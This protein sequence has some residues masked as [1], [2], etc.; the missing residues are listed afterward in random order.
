MRRILT[1]L[2]FFVLPPSAAKN[3]MVRLLG[4][5]EVHPTAILGHILILNCDDLIMGPRARIGNLTAL[6]GLRSLRLDADSSIGNL[7]F[8]SAAQ[9]LRLSDHSGTLRLG[10]GAA[11]TNRHYLDASGGI[12]IGRFSTVAGVR[13]TF[14]THG[15]DWKSSRQR[16][17]PIQIGEYCIVG[18]NVCLTP[19]TMVPSRCVVGMGS[20]VQARGREDA[21]LEQQLVVQPRAMP[22]KYIDGRY[23]VRESPSVEP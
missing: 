14:I 9:I 18:S 15:I 8:I 4:F 10:E 16:V 11:L 19:G 20:T 17:A 6:R 21:V 5:S 3:R 22:T 23:F 7:N 12:M 2:V 13:S 1:F